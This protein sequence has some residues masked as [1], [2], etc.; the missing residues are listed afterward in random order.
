LSE[1][2][3][4][5][6]RE[7][8]AKWISP[9]TLLFQ[10][11]NTAPYLKDLVPAPEP[12]RLIEMGATP[13]GFLRI[14]A[15]WENIRRPGL[16]HSEQLQ[17]YFALCLACHHATVATFVPTDVDTKI[18]GIAWHETS[19]RDVLKPMLRFALDARGWTEEGISTRS[20]RG[21]SGHNGEHWSA[22]AGGLGR[23][24]ELGDTASAKEAQAAIEA[25][26][27]REQAVFDQVAAERDGELDLLRLA[28]TLAHNRGD[29]TQG[30][31][32]WKKTPATFPLMEHLAARGRFELAVRMYQDTGLSAEGH[33]HYPLRPVKALRR[34]P[35]TLLPLCPFLDD[36]GGVVAKLEE[37]HE[38]LA[39]LVMG[40]QKLK[41]QQGYY[42]AIAGMYAVSPGAFDRAASRMPNATQRLLRSAE[43]RKLID[44]PRVS[45]E[46]MMRKRARAS[47]T[48]F[49]NSR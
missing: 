4:P 22:I 18:R 28:M 13:D 23:M 48:K 34:T 15:S 10:V 19:D 25:E 21:V 36:W 42:R 43:M 47:L 33:R 44:V 35:A 41:G 45:F 27:V 11:Y 17:D 1:P 7:A 20:I 26:I 3:T 38:V 30:M 6:L 32:F 2:L 24:L 40:C 8:W 29:L 46:S 37:S 14:L 31:G 39:A 5:P 12:G 49:R 9:E 16:P